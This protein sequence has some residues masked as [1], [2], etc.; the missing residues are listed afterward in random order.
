MLNTATYPLIIA[1]LE[2]NKDCVTIAPLMLE[3]L[4]NVLERELCSL[5]S[6]SYNN[7]AVIHRLPT[8]ILSLCFLFAR[9]ATIVITEQHGM[10]RI[11][12]ATV[13]ALSHA[14][15]AAFLQHTPLLERLDLCI[16]PQLN[17]GNSLDGIS[18][19]DPDF[20]DTAK[21]LVLQHGGRPTDLEV[22]HG[23]S[24]LRLR[25]ATSQFAFLVS[26]MRSVRSW[27]DS[28]MRFSSIHP[29]LEILD[30][31]KTVRI[32]DFRPRVWNETQ[33]GSDSIT[34][35]DFM[36]KTLPAFTPLVKT[37]ALRT[38]RRHG[39]LPLRALLSQ[40]EP[41]LWPCLEDVC[42]SGLRPPL[43][44]LHAVEERARNG[45]PLRRVVFCIPNTITSRGAPLSPYRVGS[46]AH[47]WTDVEQS[48]ADLFNSFARVSEGPRWTTLSQ[49][50]TDG[51]GQGDTFP[52]ET[53]DA[54]HGENEW[55]QYPTAIPGVRTAEGYEQ[56][57][58]RIVQV[59]SVGYSAA[60]G[61]RKPMVAG[62]GRRLWGSFKDIGRLDELCGLTTYPMFVNVIAMPLP[63]NALSARAHPG[64]EAH[65]E[66][67]SV[68][69][70]V[71]RAQV[72]PDHA[73]EVDRVHMAWV[74]V[75]QDPDR[76][77]VLLGRELLRHEREGVGHDWV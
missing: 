75:V 48:S 21:A 54:I 23:G 62:Q 71:V 26:G 63:L 32:Q 51:A 41:V 16:A 53:L 70:D 25:N 17:H 27:D 36:F 68:D 31:V 12:P 57:W 44:D 3:G 33:I 67:C 40:S 6:P 34:K 43:N 11:N 58:E 37:L 18:L 13:V 60:K 55:V 8:E 46:D 14:W 7:R 19:C 66:A 29:I 77:V 49:W 4:K 61:L 22:I 72:L 74:L 20:Y 56:A 1:M 15:L 35:S 42:V 65:A 38:I 5:S 24:C 69:G 59:C 47:G 2:G 73:A 10:H 30:E 39:D 50:W 64:P 28:T 76:G 9:D 45:H 52:T